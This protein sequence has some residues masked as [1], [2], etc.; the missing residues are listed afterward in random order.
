VTTTAYP[1]TPPRRL[2][3]CGLRHVVRWAGALVEARDELTP[4][5]RVEIEQLL[6]EQH[7]P[8]DRDTRAHRDGAGTEFT[9]PIA[10]RFDRTG[11]NVA[12]LIRLG[13]GDSLW[14]AIGADGSREQREAAIAHDFEVEI[15]SQLQADA[16]PKAPPI[17]CHSPA[18]CSR[19]DLRP[20]SYQSHRQHPVPGV[21][22]PGG[23]SAPVSGAGLPLRRSRS[24]H[25]RCLRSETG[26]VDRFPSCV[27]SRLPPNR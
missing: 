18:V 16:L 11:D 20:P 19:H 5:E 23:H 6:T 1:D 2:H 9:L 21:R 15:P 4:A 8:E 14:R 22:E 27:T 3:G 26:G 12:A 24:G 25:L 17:S 7:E 10:L 13:G